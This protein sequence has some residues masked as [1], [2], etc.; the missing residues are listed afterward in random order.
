MQRS[1]GSIQGS[2]AYRQKQARD[3][4]IVSSVIPS[5][6]TAS[7][8]GSQ[9]FAVKARGS[10]AAECASVCA[11]QNPRHPRGH[12][13]LFLG[14][15]EM[16]LLDVCSSALAWPE[17]RHREGP[18]RPLPPCPYP[19]RCLRDHRRRRTLIPRRHRAARD[20]LPLVQTRGSQSLGGSM[21][22]LRPRV[23]R[24]PPQRPP[25][26]R[27]QLVRP[28]SSHRC[29]ACHS[30]RRRRTFRACWK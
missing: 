30:S 25:Q 18:T 3:S 17:P 19:T 11:I 22:G 28:A 20:G 10:R 13:D 21:S 2:G 12:R 7:R 5:S 6:C 4:R 15:S 24:C 8:T 14:H 9:D 16:T 1:K 29:G 23:G 27:F 26:R